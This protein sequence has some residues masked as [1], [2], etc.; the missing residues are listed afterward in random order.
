MRHHRTG[1]PLLAT[2][3]LATL[4]LAPPAARAQVPDVPTGFLAW[5]VADGMSQ[6]TGF[7]FLPD[8]RALVVRKLGQIHLVTPFGIE[9]QIGSIPNIYSVGEAGLTGVAVDPGWPDDPYVYV[10]YSQA[11]PRRNIVERYRV[12]GQLEANQA[13]DLEL[14]EPRR[15]LDLYDQQSNHNGGCLRFDGA[16]RLLV[17][18]GDDV[19]TCITQEPDSLFGVLMRLDLT[20]VPDS[21]APAPPRS[22]LVAAGNPYAGSGTDK[23]LVVGQGFRNPFKFSIDPVTGLS[24]VGDVGGLVW[25]E[26]DEVDYSGQDFGWPIWEADS[27]VGVT[28][29]EGVTPYDPPIIKY[30]HDPNDPY[31]PPTYFAITGGPRYRRGAGPY[32]FPEEYEGAL[33]YAEFGHGWLKVAVEQ[34]GTWV[35]LS[36]PGQADSANWALNLYRVTDL[37]QGADGALYALTYLGEFY[38]IL[39]VPPTADAPG[40]PTP[41]VGARPV[42]PNPFRAGGAPARLPE[43]S[44]ETLVIDATGRRVRRLATPEWDGRD[45]SGRPARPGQYWL[46][47]GR[48]T[49]RVTLLP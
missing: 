34:A 17:S 15:I 20:S 19:R 44:G 14:S 37:Q 11:S 40:A 7:A 9:T 4:L 30:L 6:A 2:V 1:T 39:Y 29:G 38:R 12:T 25:E 45:D 27:L 10:F 35:P 41:P 46:V 36:V 47:A 18:H 48:R 21:A 49:G 23:A 26:I 24:Y 28:C 32:T 31:G 22:T 42:T 43:A 5:E 33:F 16:G 3:L 13:L 8:G